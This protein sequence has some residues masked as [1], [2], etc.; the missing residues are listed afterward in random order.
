MSDAPQPEFSS[1]D[2]AARL[3]VVQAQ[4]R[5]TQVL[6]QRVGMVSV[7]GILLL[8]M[9]LLLFFYRLVDHV[10]EYRRI[11]KDDA[12]RERFV[13]SFM[14]EAR[15]RETLEQDGMEF[16][17][18]IYKKVPDFGHKLLTAMEAKMPDV[19]RQAGGLGERLQMR[20]E[21]R[22]SQRLGDAMTAA[23]TANAAALQSA[24][25]NLTPEVLKAQLTVARSA[26]LARLH[27]ILGEKLAYIDPSFA[28]LHAPGQPVD[29]REV[30]SSQ[31]VDELQ[32][33]LV[34]TMI[35]MLIFELK[36]SRGD[37]I[38]G[39]NRKTTPEE[40]VVSPPALG[41]KV[42]A[43]LVP[44]SSTQPIAAPAAGGAR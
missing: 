23:F 28:V 43:P 11:A 4:L 17:Q 42:A 18:E 27:A 25:P 5:H 16:R 39:A 3:T 35:E 29:D 6:R 7:I 33:H 13:A 15:I 1:A 22:L 20:V 31:A 8:T 38:L 9:V 2:L 44:A 14:R 36:P 37:Q 34:D 32:R 41:P 26:Y 12:A 21:Q 30:V 10:L 24:A 40:P 19:E